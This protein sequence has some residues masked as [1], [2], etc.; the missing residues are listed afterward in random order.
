MFQSVPPVKCS[1]SSLVSGRSL[2]STFIHHL[3]V[4]LARLGLPAT[5]DGKEFP[6]QAGNPL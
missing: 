1:A 3:P 4:M 2:G 6:V 5:A